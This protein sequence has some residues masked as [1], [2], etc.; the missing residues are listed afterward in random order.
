MVSGNAQLKDLLAAVV[1]GG[2]RVRRKSGL[3]H[4][5]ARQKISQALQDFK[6]AALAVA[7]VAQQQRKPTRLPLKIHEAPE[8][9]NVQ[10]VQ[11]AFNL[12]QAARP[13]H[14]ALTRS[15]HNRTTDGGTTKRDGGCRSCRRV[16]VGAA[17]GPAQLFQ[18][19]RY[20]GGCPKVPFGHLR[21]LYSC[22]WRKQTV[23]ILK[24]SCTARQ[25]PSF[26]DG[27]L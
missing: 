26:A 23:R 3:G 12:S 19:R 25:R 4:R 15:H 14:R 24:G 13:R 18:G 7:V 17:R 22:P 20:P 2:K 1:P 6:H 10:M 16:G 9:V 11:H 21:L 5:G 8:I 27:L